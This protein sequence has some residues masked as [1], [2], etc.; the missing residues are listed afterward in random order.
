MHMDVKTLKPMYC[1]W[2][3]TLACNQRC[4]HCGSRAGRARPDEMDT[5]TCLR[6]IADLASLGCQV[7]TLSGG[8]PTLRRDWYRLASEI[9]QAGMIANMV[10]NGFAL[11][12]N[13]AESMRTAG[14][15]NVAVSIDGPETVHDRIRG[16]GAFE[17]S[18]RSLCLL[19]EAGLSTTVM[20]TISSLNMPHL[21]EI[22]S[23]AG[24]VGAARWRSQLGKPMGELA[25]RLDW[26]IEPRDLLELLP[27]LHRMAQAGPTRVGIGDS[28]GF[29]GPY[30]S[31]LRSVSW[32]G[33]A[34]RWAGC[35]AG[36]RAI[37]IE[38][39]GGIKGC[40]SMQAARGP[41][42]PFL[43]GNLNSR[44]LTDI[45]FD[46]DAF[47]YNRKFDPKSLSGFCR[48]CRHRLA[49][50]GGARCVAAA[51]TGG[52]SED[53]YCYHRVASLAARHPLRRIGRQVAA[54]ASAV[55]LSTGSLVVSGCLDYDVAVGF[56]YGVEPPNCEEVCCDCDY[57]ELPPELIEQCCEPVVGPEY[58]VEP[59]NC[60][61]VCCACDYGE[62]PPGVW[63]ECCEEPIITPDY[64][65]EPPE[66]EPNCEEVCCECDYGHIPPE[67]YEACCETE[68]IDCQDV[69]C[70]CDYGELPPEVIDQ[71]CS[72][73]EEP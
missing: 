70:D 14:L 73:D 43:E 57:G 4:G 65:V 13:Q 26:V 22:H 36:L 50:R 66:P 51:T 33:K 7:I 11:D 29:F 45:W 55:V 2:E 19:A 28:I 63:E 52:L 72:D 24:Q 27:R 71:C 58:G 47:A 60:E 25:D 10:T 39:D 69:C 1:V 9:R 32:K 62:L 31:E 35:Q 42:D 61:E 8:E 56:E 3:L 16:A 53:P 59:P 20:T 37:G 46:P 15:A 64:G 6:V 5:D 17:R 48:G 21:E 38:S 54:A 41:N 44:S 23:L 30:D 67:V 12:A 49:C 68:P 18:V 34:Q 40:L